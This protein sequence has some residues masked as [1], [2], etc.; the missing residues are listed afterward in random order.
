MT[1]TQKEFPELLNDLFQTRRKPDGDTYTASE[2]SNWIEDNVP[3]VDISPSYISR[4]RSGD[5]RNPSRT[6]LVA[7]RLAFK[8]PPAYFFP[9]LAH[10]NDATPPDNTV[11]LRTALNNLGLDDE[12]QRLIEA[13]TRKLRRVEK[14]AKKQAEAKTHT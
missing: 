12:S 6:I 10:L 4:L 11:L 13:L 2:I 5:L 9:E 14:A 8:T 7:L 3:G 1:I